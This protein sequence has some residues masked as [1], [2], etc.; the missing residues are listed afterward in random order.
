MRVRRLLGA[1]ALALLV[2]L[3]VAPRPAEAVPQITDGTAPADGETVQPPGPTELL[4]VFTEPL[5]E[6][7]RAVLQNSANAT[8]GLGEVGRGDDDQTW[9]VP[10]VDTLAVDVYKVTWSVGEESSGSY[11]FT[12]AGATPPTTAGTGTTAAGATTTAADAGT[13]TTD[14]SDDGAE[15]SSGTATSTG[16]GTDS[17]LARAV[18]VVARWASYLALGAFAGGLLLIV[19]AWPEG[20]EYVLTARHLRVSWLIAL[21][22]TVVLVICTRAI[23]TGSTLGSSLSPGTW[24]DLTE[25]RPGV[26]LLARLI[27]VAACGWVAFR[28]ER[29]IDPATQIPAFAAPILALVTL[30]F[31]REGDTSLGFLAIPAGIAHAFSYAAWFGG[32]VLLAR[33]VLAGPGEEDLVHALRGFARIAAPAL[34]VVVASGALLTAELVG[35]ASKLFTTGYGR[36]LLIKAVAVAAMAYIG[37]INRHTVSHRLARLDHLPARAATRLRRAIGS[38]VSVGVVVLGLSA[39]MMGSTPAGLTPPD[40][41]N[42]VKAVVTVPMTATGV[43]VNVG[44]GP[45]EVGPNSITIE[46]EQPAVGLVEMTVQIDPADGS[47][48][49]IVIP[50]TPTLSGRGT[51]VVDEVP[52]GSSGLWTIAVTSRGTSGTLPTL[53]GSFN[54]AGGDA[55][56]G[57]DDGTDETTTTGTGLGG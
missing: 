9:I 34:I 43:T 31:S 2:A 32:I 16:T 39:W 50:V 33:V 44:I 15:V 49:S 19:V 27:L 14:G 24:N 28:P 46:V 52:L 40:Q 10:I 36:L 26:A 5:S 29:V 1:S 18:A 35:G 7:P 4:M 45:A 11:L 53:T 20:V 12:I 13:S 38:E 42:S 6:A 8:V 48:A 23:D 55:D 47:V 3:A 51:L 41:S 56:D 22:S 25:T 37:T 54:V 17:D 57:G 21:I 30:G